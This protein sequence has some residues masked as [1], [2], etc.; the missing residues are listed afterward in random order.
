MFGGDLGLPYDNF[1]GDQWLLTIQGIH[2]AFEKVSSIHRE[3]C[4]D[5]LQ[6]S[7]KQF[8]FELT[9]GYLADVYSKNPCRWEDIV[10]M[11]WCLE[12]YNSFMSPI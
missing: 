7:A 11:S 2:S 10:R 3:V 1:L 12:Q 9:C 5:L 4:V 8:Q 6:S